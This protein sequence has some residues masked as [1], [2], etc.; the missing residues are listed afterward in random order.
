VLELALSHKAALMASFTCAKSSEA[1]K[2]FVVLPINDFLFSNKLLQL[3]GM[4]HG[5]IFDMLLVSSSLLGNVLFDSSSNR[6]EYF[7]LGFVQ[8]CGQPPL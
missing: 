1:R 3:R 2:R 7:S 4:P 5:G 8:Q 6:V